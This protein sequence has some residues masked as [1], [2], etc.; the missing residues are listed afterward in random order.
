MD[1]FSYREEQERR[2]NAPLAVRMRPATLDELMGQEEIVGPGTLLRRAIEADRLTSVIFYGPPGVGKTTLARLIAGYTRSVFVTLSAVTA[3]IADLRRVV[4]DARDR[5]GMYGQKTTLFIDEIHRFNKAQQDA[6]LPHM[7]DGLVI[8]IGATTENPYFEVNKALL[9]RSLVFALRPLTP[10]ALKT[11]ARRAIADKERGLGTMPLEVHEEALDHWVRY[12]EGDARRLLGAL[13]LA[14]LT[15]A[16]DDRG[17]IVITRS[18]AEA[19]IQRRAVVYDREGDAHYDTISAFIKSVRGS[20]PDAALLWLAKMLKAGEDPLF[21]AR[22][23][24]ILASEDIGNADPQG[25]VVATSAFQAVQ[26]LGMPE[27]RIPLAQ[28]TTYLATAPKSN[29]SYMALEK[30][31]AEVGQGLDL[32]VPRHLRDAHY[33]GAKALGHGEGYLYPHD[34]PGHWVEQS[35]L[36]PGMAPRRYYR[37]SDQGYEEQI[38]RFMAA[39]RKEGELSGKEKGGAGTSQGEGRPDGEEHHVEGSGTA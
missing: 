30:A 39:R 31:L 23:L 28:A 25:L 34:Y 15:T 32:T 35:Y 38:A 6:L 13:E 17:R 26:W 11:I 3:G 18:V 5:L 24:V 20:D 14:A 19:S 27:G 29:A 36:P 22:R 9:S 16:P 1:L 12:C 7:E 37:P 4:D 33:G 8:L 10:E 21:I 2:V